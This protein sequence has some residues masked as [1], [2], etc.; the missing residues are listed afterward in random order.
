MIANSHP[1]IHI[2]PFKPLV[3]SV[4]CKFSGLPGALT[5]T[6]SDLTTKLERHS[7]AEY[8]NAT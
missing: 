8:L 2:H 4:G 1:F 5:S 6:A 3:L 7:Q